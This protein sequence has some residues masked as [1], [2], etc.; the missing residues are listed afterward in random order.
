[1][2]N[3]PEPG[4]LRDVESADVYKCGRLAGTLR[5]DGDDVVFTYL[6]EYR[7]DP[8]TPPI[9]FTLPK[10][11]EA[12]RTTGGSVPPFFAGL[13][14]E[15]ARLVAITALTRTSEDDHLSLLL[16][17]G[18]DTVGDVQVLPTGLSLTEP[19]PLFGEDPATG[20]R[21]PW[22]GR[23][24]EI[25]FDEAWTRRLAEL[26]EQRRQELSAPE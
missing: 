16:A 12:V 3:W 19:P 5:R 2:S 9:A 22:I 11:S 24:G 18:A 20:L 15:G 14:P 13:L 10:H 7:A 8:E 4:R 25:G 23:L 26:I 1:M 6:E 21:Q 17:V